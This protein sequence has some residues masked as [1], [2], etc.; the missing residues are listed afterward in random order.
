MSGDRRR[1][2][3]GPLSTLGLGV[4]AAVVLVDQITKLT[5]DAFLEVGQRIDLLPVLSLLRVNNTGIALSFLSGSDAP[6]IL[7]MLVV[8]AI[9][10]IMWQRTSDGGPQ[11]AVGFALITGGAIG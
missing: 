8:T 7:L 5:A 1:R 11:V 6:L 9:V 4:V 10:L 2:P 3:A